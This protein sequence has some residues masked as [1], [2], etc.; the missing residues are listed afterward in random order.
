MAKFNV[1]EATGRLSELIQRAM[2]GEEVVIAM[3][4]KPVAKLV[5]FGTSGAIR[6]PG[7]A[8]GRIWMA[9]DFDA[10]LEDFAGYA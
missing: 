5:P 3:S 1:A 2:A 4:G 8:K 7:F 10:P 9:P 6:K